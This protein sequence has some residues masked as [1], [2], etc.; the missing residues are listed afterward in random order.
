MCIRPNNFLVRKLCDTGVGTFV[1]VDEVGV[2]SLAGSVV[3]AAV[4]LA[5]DAIIKGLGDSKLL[6]PK[7]RQA[8]FARIREVA[9]ALAIGLDDSSPGSVKTFA[10][11]R[12]AS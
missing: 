2:G 11:L 9:V 12:R 10:V 8:L 1:G 3:A 7:R 6:T 5:P 4:I